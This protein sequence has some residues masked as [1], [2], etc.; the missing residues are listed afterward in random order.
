MAEVAGKSQSIAKRSVVMSSI[1]V[2]SRITGYMRIAVMAYA[3]GATAV[4]S[5]GAAKVGI[6]DSY[7]LSN[8]IPNIIFDLLVGGILYSLFLPII[9][10]KMSGGDEEEVWH[11]ASSMINATAVF[12]LLLSVA[13]FVLAGPITRLMTASRAPAEA[14]LAV[15]FFRFFTWQMFFY[16]LCAVFTGVLNAY[17]HFVAPVVAP[18]ANNVIVIATGFIFA[19]L[20]PRDFNL[21]L[22][23]LAV[24]TTLGVVLMAAVQV[25]P[26]IKIGLRYR[27]VMDFA[28]P[29]IRKLGKLAVPILAYTT[30]GQIGLWVTNLIAWRYTGGVTGF[31]YSWQFFQLPFG[32]FAVSI[33]TAIYPELSEQIATGDMDGFKRT[34]SLGVRSLGLIMIPLSVFLVIFSK[35]LIQVALEYG[36]FDA[37]A[38]AITSKMLFYFGFGV[39]F[40]AIYMLIVRTFYAMQ[41]TMTPMKV[42]AIGVPVCIAL[43][44][45]LVKYMGVS[46]LALAQT[47][48]FTFTTFIVFYLLRLRVGPLGVR[49]I[50]SSTSKYALASL[51]LGLT[52]YFAFQMISSRYWELGFGADRLAK[53]AGALFKG[54]QL[55]AA[56]LAGLIIYIIAIYLLRVEEV[57]IIKRFGRRLILLVRS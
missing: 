4:V 18:L 56:A 43:N 22:I 35:P 6:G 55:T 29:S 53:V 57:S 33:I 1:T 21:A 25:P 9:V 47:I 10:E 24:G 32:I 45:I 2:V 46:G 12:A 3:L 40:Y 34:V 14:A 7:N 39:Y 20:A 51:L 30:F 27:F 23:I 36:R 26:L 11:V 15:W 54:G 8:V 16:G 38:T 50:I 28:H 42:N 37:S 49:R 13:G 17:R 31:Q 48:T 5:F 52:S 44:F 41:D 19:A